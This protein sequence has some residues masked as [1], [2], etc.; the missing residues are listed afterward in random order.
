MLW[1]AWMVSEKG[2]DA[3][4]AVPWLVKAETPAGAVAV[5]AE[6]KPELHVVAVMKAGE[7]PPTA[8]G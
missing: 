3:I 6:T 1:I 2:R 7:P 8:S 5:M 4:Q